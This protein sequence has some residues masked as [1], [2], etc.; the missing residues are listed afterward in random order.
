MH[1]SF[2]NKHEQNIVVTQEIF[3]RHLWNKQFNHFLPDYGAKYNVN[4]ILK[5][6]TNLPSTFAMNNNEKLT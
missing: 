6:N 4:S 3:M 1:C 5:H 2:A